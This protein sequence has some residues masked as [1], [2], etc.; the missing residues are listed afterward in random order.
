MDWQALLNVAVIVLLFL[1]M[2]RGC[3]GMRSGCGT[4]DGGSRRDP[5]D[6]APAERERNV[7]VQ[8]DDESTGRRS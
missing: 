4:R 8:K 3:G 6:R 1:V 7:D 2:M 5:G